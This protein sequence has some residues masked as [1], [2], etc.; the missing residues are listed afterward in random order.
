METIGIILAAL[1]GLIIGSFLNAVIYRLSQS[2]SVAK[3]RSYC[4]HCKHQLSWLDLFPVVS[5]IML[6]G[7]CRYCQKTISWQYPAV[8]VVTA[9]V[10]ALLVS[11]FWFPYW[12]YAV[13]LLAV[14]SALI[15]IFVYDFYYYL[16]PDKVLF[17]AA[18]VMFSYRLFAWL[19]NW[20]SLTNYL[21]AALVA[22]GFFLAI[23]LVSRGRW[24]GFGDVKL[25]I[26]LGLMLGWPN[27]IVGLW[28]SFLLGAV[29]GVAAM[30]ASKKGM[31]SEM[32][33]APFLILGTF[34]ALF[35]GQQLLQWYTQF[36]V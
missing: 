25:A 5:F 34:L 29:V 26:L 17:P 30:V 19:A 15:V 7:K 6:A 28:L 14:A 9:V 1:L 3:G 12:L 31:K 13:A 35:W 27:I 36:I 4:P 16:I 11:Q 20:D 23:F 32:P 24:I 21:V 22:A 33:F 10:F 8:E 2:E 18:A